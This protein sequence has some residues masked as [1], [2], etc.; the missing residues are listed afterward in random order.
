MPN[1]LVKL[2]QVSVTTSTP[3]AGPGVAQK[4]Y[5]TVNGLTD[6]AGIACD[7]SE[8][9]YVSDFDKHVIYRYKR[10]DAASKILAG[11]YGVSGLTDGQGGF[12]KFNK[13]AALA[14]DNRG[15]VFILDSGNSRIRKMDENGNV[16]TVATIPDDVALDQ[17]GALVVVG[18]DIFFIDN[19]A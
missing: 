19:N 7:A 9:I 16:Y 8:N 14:C 13:P 15:N 12:A 3:S 10:G 5:I 2:R 17:V 11:T 4:V 1:R 6:G 18:E